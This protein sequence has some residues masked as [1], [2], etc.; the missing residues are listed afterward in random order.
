[1]V[2]ESSRGGLILSFSCPRLLLLQQVDVKLALFKTFLSS[3]SETQAWISG[4]LDPDEGGNRIFRSIDVWDLPHSTPPLLR[5]ILC[6]TSNPP[7]ERGWGSGVVP[8]TCIP[9]SSA[10]PGFL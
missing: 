3:T 4:T 1:M 9:L 6:L 7:S 5:T 10:A 2:Q 8:Y